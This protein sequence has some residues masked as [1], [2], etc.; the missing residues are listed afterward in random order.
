[1]ERTFE[2]WSEIFDSAQLFEFNGKK[3]VW[4]G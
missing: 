3:M 2:D 1:M 4:F